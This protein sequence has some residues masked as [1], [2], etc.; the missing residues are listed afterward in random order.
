MPRA[1]I[2]P[3]DSQKRARDKQADRRRDASRL[4]KG[5]VSQ[6]QLSRE[7]GFFSPLPLHAFR[8]VA[9]GGRSIDKLR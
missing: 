4:S 3:L 5:A 2:V 7:N 6:E 9:I 8:I 1:K